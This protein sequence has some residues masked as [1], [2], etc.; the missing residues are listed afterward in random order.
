M[1]KGGVKRG[2]KRERDR[3]KERKREL[4]KKVLVLFLKELCCAECRALYLPLLPYA[5]SNESLEWKREREKKERGENRGQLAC[6]V[7]FPL[8]LSLSL[9]LLC[10]SLW[11]SLPLY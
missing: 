4:E 2:R 7:T 1:K 10:R 5:L 6:E 3:E 11:Q 9:S 8:S